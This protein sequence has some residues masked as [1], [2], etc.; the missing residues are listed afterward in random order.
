MKEEIRNKRF[1][2][3]R[4][5]YNLT[6]AEIHDCKFMGIEDG[7]SALKEAR[8]I[9]VYDTLFALRY[10]LWHVH[11]FILDRIQMSDTAR[12]ALW[13]AVDG[14]IVDSELYGVKAVRECQNVDIDNCVINSPEFGWKSSDIKL[15][16]T[17]ITAE[18]LFLDSQ[19]ITLRNVQMFGKYSFQYVEN[20]TIEDC[21]LD[22]K[23][24]FWH[25]KNVTVKNSIIKGEYLAWFSEGLTFINCHIIGTQPLCYCKN[26]KLINCT[27]EGCDLTFEYSDVEADIKG[28]IISI[29]NP[30][31]GIITVD[32]VGEIIKEK[33]I[34]ECVGEI[35]IRK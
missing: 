31:S 33:P 15:A 9:E 24:A 25:S 11:N 3:E 34:M 8:D 4:A 27:T 18:Y 10:P 35:N 2:E 23:D 32:S 16:N 14:K 28:H 6:N 12:A 22:T 26:L 7:E 19:N 5:L 20:L 29:K 21:N 1:G 17:K 13:Y 30:K